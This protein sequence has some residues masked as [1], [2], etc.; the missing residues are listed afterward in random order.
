[1]FELRTIPLFTLGK[2]LQPPLP[3]P[4]WQTFLQIQIL[5][6]KQILDHS[7][8]GNKLRKSLFW[9]PLKLS[10]FC[11]LFMMRRLPD[12]GFP[13]NA[14]LIEYFAKRNQQPSRIF[15]H[16][17]LTPLPFQFT[18]RPVDSL[19]TRGTR[20]TQNATMCVHQPK[21]IHHNTTMCVLALAITTL[22]YPHSP[23]LRNSTWMLQKTCA[24]CYHSH[25]PS[26]TQ[27]TTLDCYR[28]LALLFLPI[29]RSK[30][31]YNPTQS[32]RINFW[33]RPICRWSSCTP[34]L[35][36]VVVAAVEGVVL[37]VEVSGPLLLVRPIC[38]LI[39]RALVAQSCQRAEKM[40]P[41][42]PINSTNTAAAAN[43]DLC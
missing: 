16:L 25:S 34:E 27:N 21:N 24:T 10:E 20:W 5:I 29:V 43:K 1:M 31:F 19:L 7:S 15:N 28:K 8:R 41:S 38:L 30:W 40:P 13:K 32:R 3:L 23:L 2:F 12:K 35:L 18:T 14:K 33:A 17:T 36:V 39:I 37:L 22:P 42:A 6:R 26:L 9:A 4:A 11:V